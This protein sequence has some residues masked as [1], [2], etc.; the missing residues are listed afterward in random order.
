MILD[1]QKISRIKTAL[2]FHSKGLSISDIAQQLRINRNSVAKY[3]E[4]LQI[5]GQ[6]DVKKTG[7]SKI[8]TISPRVPVS[9]MLGFS[10]DMIIMIDRSGRIMQVNDPLLLFTGVSREDLIGNKFSDIPIGFLKDIPVDEVLKVSSETKIETIEKRVM[11]RGNEKYLHIKTASTIF[12]DGKDGITILI[13]DITERKKLEV[14]LRESEEKYR[15]VVETQ[16][17]F[18]CR[19]RPDGTHVFVN[20]AYCRYFGKAYSDLIGK[21]FR[22]EIF[23]D[24]QARIKNHFASLTKDHPVQTIEHRIIMHD[25][26]IRWQQWVDRVIFDDAGRIVEYQTIGRDI[27]E[28]K[29]AELAL[30]EREKLY[31]SVIE[32]IQDVF[33]RTDNDGILIMA[34]PSWASMLGYDVP[35]EYIGQNIADKF[36]FDPT[37][38]KDFLKTIYANGFVRDYEITLKHKNGTPVYVSTNSHL[39]YDES[40]AILGIEGIFRDISERRSAAEKIQRFISQREFLSQKLLE[41]IE[42]PPE[43]DI[44]EKI[45]ADL[46]SLVPHA[47]IAVNSFDSATGILSPRAIVGDTDLDKCTRCIGQSPIGFRFTI[48][49]VAINT[50]RNGRLHHVPWPL[51]DVLFRNIPKDICEKISASVNIGEIYGIGFTKS[52]EVFGNATLFLYQGT[53]IKEN[54]LIETYAYQASFALQRRVS[55]KSLKHRQEIF[56]EIIGLFP[57]PLSIIEPG[58]KYRYVNTAFSRIFGYTL[59]DFQTGRGWFLLAYPD[60]VY[61]KKA[62]ATWKSDLD[63][64]NVDNPQSRTFTVRCK[65]GTDREIVFRLVRLSDGKQCMM[66]EISPN[67]RSLNG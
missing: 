3:L 15:N 9:A 45:A 22:P 1:Y 52:G 51:Y 20:D 11:C 67:R 39:Y 7:P 35:D 18:I 30:A 6:V 21:K 34:S 4:I 36:W 48:D 16:T 54:Q 38:R 43:S 49:P 65:D 66:Y 46:K 5:S 31:R 50:L 60:P 19:F 26:D 14:S 37:L 62:I 33:Y 10:S 55:E 57:V 40:G 32:N 64:P 25:G 58:G 13:E 24:D 8:Y 56:S 41:F 63:L 47:M 27:T 61:R 29:R 53:E 59:K 2:R 17:E 44:Y 23:K 12:D 42:L 28:R